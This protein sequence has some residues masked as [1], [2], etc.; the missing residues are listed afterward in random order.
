VQSKFGGRGQAG[1]A[2]TDDEDRQLRLIGNAIVSHGVMVVATESASI[3]D[4]TQWHAPGG[5]SGV[6]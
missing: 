1:R 4:A 6:V 2:S 5:M 3:T